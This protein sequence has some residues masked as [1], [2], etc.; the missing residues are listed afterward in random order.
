MVD[1]NESLFRLRIVANSDRFL[2]ESNYENNA[3]AM[4]FRMS[5]IRR[6]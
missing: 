5:Q 6:S 1:D 4:T 3:A 2:L